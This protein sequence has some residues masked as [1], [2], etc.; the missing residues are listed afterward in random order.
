MSALNNY[1]KKESLKK[2]DK[3]QIIHVLGSRLRQKQ[4]LGNDKTV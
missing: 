3:K 2:N 4:T 1:L